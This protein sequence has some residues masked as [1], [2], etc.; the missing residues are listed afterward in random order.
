MP[1]LR[2]PGESEMRGK[3]IMCGDSKALTE[4]EDQKIVKSALEVERGT[5][6]GPEW[7][8]VRGTIRQTG[9]L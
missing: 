6:T 1:E 8:W 2:P 3:L 4:P 7:K 9:H 5:E